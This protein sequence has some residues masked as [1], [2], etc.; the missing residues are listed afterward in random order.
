VT[1]VLTLPAG[2][3]GAVLEVQ[4]PSGAVMCPALLVSSL[5]LVTQPAWFV[6]GTTGNDNATGATLATAL[7]TLAEFSRRMRGA[8]LVGS[9]TQ[10]NEAQI[11]VNLS[12]SFDVNDQLYLDGLFLYDTTSLVIQGTVTNTALVATITNVVGLGSGGGAPFT[13]TTTGVDWTTTPERRVLLQGTF[14]AWIG[15]VIDANNITISNP[16]TTPINGQTLTV[17]TTTA[18]PNLFCNID[19]QP[20]QNAQ[21]LNSQFDKVIINDLLIGVPKNAITTV[22]IPPLNLV[23]T[24]RYVLF[25]CKVVTGLIQSI[26]VTLNTCQLLPSSATNSPRLEVYSTNIALAFCSIAKNPASINNHTLQL[27]LGT[28]ATFR[29]VYSEAVGVLCVDPGVQVVIAS[30]NTHIQ[31]SP[32]E[33]LRLNAGTQVVNNSGGR[34]SGTGNA[35]FGINCGGGGVFGYFGAVD[36]PTIT[37]ASGDTAVVGTTKAYAAIPFVNNPLFSG[38][39]QF[40]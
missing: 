40:S 22:E 24:A 19:G 7:K 2:P 36:K 30:G 34:L 20:R 21:A 12:G 18:I 31:N 5:G 38:I 4:S 23:G 29:S 8:T 25:R 39:Y 3:L 15:R 33:G 37:G 9:F 11:Q 10:P 14:T 16:N 13:L 6:D 27:L 26:G 1:L 32:V 28:T 35:T 17:Q